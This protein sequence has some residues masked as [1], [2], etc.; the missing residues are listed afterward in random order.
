MRSFSPNSKTLCSMSDTTITQADVALG[1]G[2]ASFSNVTGMNNSRNFQTTNNTQITGSN[3]KT[4]ANFASTLLIGNDFSVKYINSISASRLDAIYNNSALGTTQDVFT[5]DLR[6]SSTNNTPISGA[7]VQLINVSGSTLINTTT[8]SLGRIPQQ[9]VLLY[10]RI[11]SGGLGPTQNLSP[12]TLI[13]NKSGFNEYREVT[14]Y[15][16]S[17]AL[18]KTIALTQ[19]GS[20]DTNIFGGTFY[21]SIIY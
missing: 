4:I 15:S 20:L 1:T 13:V 3:I 14:T 17:I 12:Y 8:D 21:N 5:Y 10:Q 7:S 2:L 18:E 9:E 6:V 11:I 19:T 16:S